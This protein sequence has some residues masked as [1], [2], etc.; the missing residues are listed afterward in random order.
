MHYVLCVVLRSHL[1][2]FGSSYSFY[3]AFDEQCDG[4]L[5]GLYGLNLVS[6]VIMPKDHVLVR[7]IDLTFSITLVVTKG[8]Q[9]GRQLPM[10]LH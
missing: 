3:A 7:Q 4:W 9:Q 10:L 5:V 1:P 8:L 2:C 6:T